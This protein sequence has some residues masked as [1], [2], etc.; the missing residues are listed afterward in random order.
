M[1]TRISLL[2]RMD[3]A[4]ACLRVMCRDLHEKCEFQSRVALNDPQ[5][6]AP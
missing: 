4:Q 3:D 1:S 2:F 6:A 5:E